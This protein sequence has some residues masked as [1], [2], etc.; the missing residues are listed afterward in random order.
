MLAYVGIY[1][2]LAPER[3][4]ADVFLTLVHIHAHHLVI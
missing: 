1:A 2:A 3:V 4:F